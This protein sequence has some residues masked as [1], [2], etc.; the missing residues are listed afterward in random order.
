[1]YDAVIPLP[2]TVA[3]TLAT[4]NAA[5][6]TIQHE[7]ESMASESEQLAE[8][9]RELA[10]LAKAADRIAGTLHSIADRLL[11]SEQTDNGE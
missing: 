7:G 1:M 2:P 11:R 3:T 10:E 6:F 9:R 8:V 5:S 4:R